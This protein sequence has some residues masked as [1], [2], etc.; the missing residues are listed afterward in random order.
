[1]GWCGGVGFRSRRGCCRADVV[2]GAP[3]AIYVCLSVCLY[4]FVLRLSDEKACL[5]VSQ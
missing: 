1:M 3:I 4:R 2:D 5:W